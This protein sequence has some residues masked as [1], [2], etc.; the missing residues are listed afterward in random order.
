MSKGKLQELSE[1]YDITVGLWR[2]ANPRRFVLIGVSES[3]HATRIHM[4]VGQRVPLL[5]GAIGRCA[6]ATSPMT[7]AEIAK[8]LERVVWQSRPSLA[9]Y[10]RQIDGVRRMG[11]A[12]DAGQWRRGV[13]TVGA[14][15]VDQDRVLQFGIT[16]SMFTDQHDHSTVQT[17]CEEVRA[18]AHYASQRA[19]GGVSELVV[20]TT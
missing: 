13:A 5:A 17:I 6:A 14:P 7:D 16:A 8:E 19:F 4:A 12:I 1:T 15:I 2:L 10:L 18:A 11:W 9:D 3:P 20:Q